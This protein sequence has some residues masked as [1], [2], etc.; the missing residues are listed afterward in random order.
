[1]VA[2]LPDLIAA[3]AVD[4]SGARLIEQLVVNRHSIVVSGATGAG[5]TTLLNVLSTLI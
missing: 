1:A 5:K 4:R 3:G 2:G